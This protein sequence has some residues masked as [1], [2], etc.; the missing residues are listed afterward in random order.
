MSAVERRFDG[1]Y[2]GDQIA[3]LVQLLRIPIKRD[4]H[5]RRARCGKFEQ[6]RQPLSIL[7]LDLWS[8]QSH[9]FCTRQR[10][11]LFFELLALNFLFFFAIFRWRARRVE[12]AQLE[13][14]KGVSN[15]KSL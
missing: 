9:W 6:A 15:Q 3:G 5:L 8:V 11:K 14:K 2:T 10:L 7:S 12:V 1:H 4:L 13:R